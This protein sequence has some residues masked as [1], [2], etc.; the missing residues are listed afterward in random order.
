MTSIS[1][2]HFIK[3]SVLA[4]A[5][6]FT[7]FTAE[8][9]KVMTVQGWLP[10]RKL[11]A[12]LPHEHV[13]VDFSGAD[14]IDTSKYD[15][16]E[17]FETVLPHLQALKAAG[18]DTLIECTPNYIGRSPLLLK[19]LSEATGIHLLTNTGYYGAVDHKYLPAHVA[20]ESPRQ[21]A[22]RW[23]DEWKNGIEGT[24]IRPGFMKISVDKAPLSERQ[25]KIVEAAAIA[26]LESGL[27]V[28]S[29]TIGGEAAMEELD[30]LQKNGVSPEAFIW[31]HAQSETDTSYHATAARMGAWVEFDGLNAN[32]LT[33]ET[34][35]QHL[36][37]LSFMKKENLL[38]RTLLSQDAGWY[39]PGKPG[40]GKFAPFTYLF[41][42]FVPKLRERFFSKKELRQVMRENPARAFAVKI[43][44]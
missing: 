23:L 6:I 41:D 42:E 35:A 10:A 44:T 7:S 43:R 9:Q 11:G 12:V 17:I 16:D 19:R 14:T 36:D 37:C 28:A 30:I 29:H 38:H 3:N 13:L 33:P 40:G 21:L 31:I 24:G 25:R 26:H 34:V 22:D 15:L 39:E 20:T 8:K 18:C 4:S 27:T 5:A 32:W 1:R 2:R